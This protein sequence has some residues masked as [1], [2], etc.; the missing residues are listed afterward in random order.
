MDK[1]SVIIRNGKHTSVECTIKIW[2]IQD[3]SF[4][5]SLAESKKPSPLPTNREQYQA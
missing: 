1:Y 5:E 4:V 2:E 3:L